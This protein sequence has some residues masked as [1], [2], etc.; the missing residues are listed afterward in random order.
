LEY[1]HDEKSRHEVCHS[2]II[3]TLICQMSQ[4]NKPK[5]CFQNFHIKTLKISIIFDIT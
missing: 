1:A 3:F 5:I 2:M 4:N